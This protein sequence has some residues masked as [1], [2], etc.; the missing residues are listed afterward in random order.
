M[1]DNGDI[2]NHLAELQ[3]TLTVV[4]EA[5]RGYREH[6]ERQGWSPT[7]AEQLAASLFFGPLI[8]QSSK[9]EE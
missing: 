8:A 9:K 1:V 3:E 4:E 2:A 6:L 5:A 7:M